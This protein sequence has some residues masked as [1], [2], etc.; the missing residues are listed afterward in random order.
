[1]LVKHRW[2]IPTMLALLA[3]VIFSGSLGN[4]FTNWDDNDYVTENALIRQIDA[5]TLREMFHPT[6]IFVGNWAPITIL[7]YSFDYAIWKLDPFG[8][9]LTNLLL[10]VLCTLLIY[11]LLSRLL[12]G[13]DPTAGRVPAAVAAAIFAI[14]P[15]QVESVAWIAERKN[16]LGMALFLGAFLAWLRATRPPFSPATSVAFLALLIGALLAKIHAAIL[17]PMLLLYEWIERPAT[18]EAAISPK[19]RAGLLFLAFLPTFAIG[20]VTLGAQRVESQPRITGDLMGAIATAPVLV[21]RYAKDLLFPLDR[22]AILP[23]VVYESPWEGLPLLALIGVLGWLL[24]ALHIRHRKP[25]ITFFTLWFFVALA[26]VL[27]FLPLPV[28]AAD[29]YQYWAAPGLLALAGLALSHGWRLL[30]PQQRQGLTGLTAIIAILRANLGLVLL[31][32][33]KSEEAESELR[34]ALAL[35]PKATDTRITLAGTLLAT[36]RIDEAERELREALRL[37]PRNVLARTN[38]GLVLINRG[39]TEEAETEFQEVIRLDPENAPARSTLGLVL[40]KL[41]KLDAAKLEFREALRLNPQ[42]V[43]AR[44]NLRLVLDQLEGQPMDKQ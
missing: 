17:P 23:R 27:N 16:V 35:D 24:W 28:L 29:R 8:Y 42:D 2:A 4:D 22:A 44:S 21:F 30:M 5:E 15:V 10:H 11:W 40:M 26:P 19:A 43:N 13:G 12:G 7:S 1:M 18:R 31:R 38:L 34:E 39:K 14:H 37:D 6:S 3:F 25:H 33:G 36:G 32:L 9:H 20:W 41:G